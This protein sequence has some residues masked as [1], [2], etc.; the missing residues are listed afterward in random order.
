MYKEGETY[1][2]YPRYIEQNKNDGQQFGSSVRG[3]EIRYCREI[4]SWVFMHPDI[5]TSLDGNKEN[6]C[7]WL[8]RSP[9]T[10]DYDILSTTSGAW[11]AWIGEVIPL[12]FVSI[13]DNECAER[14]DCNYHGDCED[15]VCNCDDSHF[16]DSCE[17]E[18]PCPSLATEKAHTFGKCEVCTISFLYTR[19]STLIQ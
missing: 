11:G 15:S 18:L 5:L 8:W 14:S 6:E 17:F 13:T 4:G 16:G 10:Q 3:A 9:Q 7:S 19:R 12:A 1:D 2:G